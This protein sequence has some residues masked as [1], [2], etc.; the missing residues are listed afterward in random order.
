VRVVDK[1]NKA[2]PGKPNLSFTVKNFNTVRDEIITV[3]NSNSNLGAGESQVT[4]ARQVCVRNH[5]SQPGAGE[6]PVTSVDQIT[7]NNFNSHNA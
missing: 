7:V 1:C 5:N 4:N 2:N 3:N 6:S